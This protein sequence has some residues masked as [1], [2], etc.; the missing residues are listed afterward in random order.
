MELSDVTGELIL[1]PRR[2]TESGAKPFCKLLEETGYP[3]LKTQ[4]SVRDIR[5]ALDANPECVSEWIRYSENKRCRSGWCLKKEGVKTF[6][7]AYSEAASTSDISENHTDDLD[8]CT[9]FIKCQ[10]DDI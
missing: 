1:L 7:V 8:A 4:V 5:E 3:A 2:F 9:P 10:I 6:I